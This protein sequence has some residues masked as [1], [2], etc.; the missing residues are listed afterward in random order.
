[1][2]HPFFLGKRGKIFGPFS[3]DQIQELK[4]S[5]QLLNYTYLWNP[6]QNAWVAIDPPP[7]A[8]SI[9]PETS[10]D[11]L[12]ASLAEN[13]TSSPLP[14]QKSAVKPQALQSNVISLKKSSVPKEEYDVIC[15]HPLANGNIAIPA[16]LVGVSKE[17]CEIFVEDS[18]MES[19]GIPFP[20]KT[21]IFMN[22][23]QNDSGKTMTAQGTIRATQRDAQGWYLALTWQAEVPTLLQKHV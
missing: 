13:P 4:Q 22:F 11:D 3:S 2:S 20:K 21:Q 8:P 18:Q 5:G 17:G 7:P 1:M 16:T 6:K 9:A 15:Y 19:R 23:L 10:V 12:L 14:E